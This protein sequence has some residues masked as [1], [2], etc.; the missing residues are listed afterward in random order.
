VLPS[1]I[2]MACSES[3]LLLMQSHVRFSG[4]LAE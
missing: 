3:V 4:L 2:A 1:S